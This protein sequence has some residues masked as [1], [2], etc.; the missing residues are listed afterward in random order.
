MK[1]PDL[2]KLT[3]E[4]PRRYDILYH[5]EWRGDHGFFAEGLT[6]FETAKKLKISQGAKF[7]LL[8]CDQPRLEV[9]FVNEDRELEVMEA[10]RWLQRFEERHGK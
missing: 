9:H 6:C 10:S 2:E 8:L 5:R 1:L 4:T 3:Q 7:G